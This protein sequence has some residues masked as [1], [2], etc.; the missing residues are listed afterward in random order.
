MSLT[1]Y[2][3]VESTC[4]QKVRLVLSAKKLEWN[5]KRLNLRKGEQFSPE[6]LR[7][8]PKAVVPTLVHGDCV[9]RESSVINEYLDDTF[10]EHAMKPESSCER[11]LMRLFVKAFDEE[12]HPSVGILTY[13][14]VLRH[15]MNE[16][17]TPEEL[18]A[19]FERIVDPGRRERQRGTHELGLESPAAK[20][21]L[22]ALDKVV[23][24]MESAL[25]NTKWLAGEKYSLADAAATPYMVRMKVLKLDVLWAK[26]PAVAEWLEKACQSQNCLDLETPWGAPN[27]IDMV[28]AYVDKASVEI[29]DF[30]S[31][32]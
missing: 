30:T 7:L 2:H 20:P 9:I 27:F 14:I 10:P 18:N 5:E 13:A 24:S 15:Q 11:A 29:A 8:N 16:I 21:A 23:D 22:H 4:A 12:V 1:F 26:R 17:K 19:H 32:I 25:K 28:S 3:S 31:S 6:Y